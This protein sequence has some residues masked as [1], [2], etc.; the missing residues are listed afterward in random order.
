MVFVFAR[1]EP[2][3][4]LLKLQAGDSIKR[5]AKRCRTYTINI[6]DHTFTRSDSRAIV[7]KIGSDELFARPEWLGKPS[8][9]LRTDGSK[10]V[11]YWTAL[12]AKRLGIIRSLIVTADSTAW[13]LT[14]TWSIFCRGSVIH[15]LPGHVFTDSGF[16][17]FVPA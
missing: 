3:I 16:V 14:L 4:N 1:G 15:G 6:G 5:L 12:G 9:N 11:F 10:I 13:I 2:G 8:A 17:C 7:E